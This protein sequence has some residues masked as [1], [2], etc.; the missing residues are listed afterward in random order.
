MIS[1]KQRHCDRFRNSAR[2]SDSDVRPV[3]HLGRNRITLPSYSTSMF[4][5]Q[6]SEGVVKAGI[7]AFTFVKGRLKQLSSQSFAHG[8]TD[9]MS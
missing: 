9:S 6:F 8:F 3:T 2:M 1:P 4:I 7:Q 5:V